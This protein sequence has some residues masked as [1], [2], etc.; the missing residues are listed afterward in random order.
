MMFIDWT[1]ELAP[2]LYGMNALLVISAV[3]VAAEPMA[4]ALRKW[5][6]T[7]SRP[8]FH[9]GRPALGHR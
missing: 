4:R 7:L 3:A 6:G 1:P 2:I 9:L 8:R 5:T